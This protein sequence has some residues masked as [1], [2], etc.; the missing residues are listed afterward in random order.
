MHGILGGSHQIVQDL[1][2]EARECWQKAK[3]ERVSVYAS[4]TRNKWHLITSRPKRPLKS[5]ILDTGVKEAILEDALDFLYS[6]EWYLERGIPF[7]RGYLLVSLHPHPHDAHASFPN[8]LWYGAPGSGKTS[9]IQSIAGELNLDVYVI[10][11]SQ[12]GLDDSSLRGLIS[13]LPEHCIALMEDIDA[14][15]HHTLTRDL[16]GEGETPEETKGPNVPTVPQERSSRLSLSGLLNALDGVGVQEGRLLFA[17]TNRYEA[18]DAA[19]RRPGRMDVHV[20]FK[21]ASRY[22]VG[23]L[24]RRFYLPSPRTSITQRSL[25]KDTAASKGDGGGRKVS[26]SGYGTP[27]EAETEK[28]IDVELPTGVQDQSL[29]TITR[30]KKHDIEIPP[31]NLTFS[32]SGSGSWFPRGSSQ[33]PRCRITS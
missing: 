15:F 16:P 4:G 7:R 2:A 30:R 11:L 32:W 23:E 31:G 28:L 1:L 29:A 19:L 21:L 9:L 17:T 3:G 12:A 8:R 14:A 22:Q 13:D 10:S 27:V 6:K 24:F 5:I 20:G 25:S 18:L 26:D 33:W